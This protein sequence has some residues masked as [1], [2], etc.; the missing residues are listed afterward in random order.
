M[1]ANI[2]INNM[3]KIIKILERTLAT[4]NLLN[5]KIRKYHWNVEWENFSELH[6]F[7]EWLYDESSENIDEIAERIRMLWS[8]TKASYK[9][10]L[11]LSI[12]EEDENQK[13]SKEEM[14]KN[15]LNDKEKIIRQM[16]EDIE[17]I[18]ELWDLWTEDFLT[19]L[20]QKNEK[21]AWMLRS[22]TK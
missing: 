6:S 20:I 4:E 2:W 1:E 13:T 14:I 8:Y 9:E 18:W 10:Y 17:E 22:M 7:F 19:W 11:E 3:E 16:R 21:N 15:L 12:I 5:L